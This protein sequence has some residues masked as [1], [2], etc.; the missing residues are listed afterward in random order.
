MI[1]QANYRPIFLMRRSNLGLSLWMALCGITFYFN[2][3]VTQAQTY[4]LVWEDEFNQFDPTTPS[5]NS[6]YNRWDVDRTAWNIEVVDA[7]ANGEIQKYRDS[8]DN[9]RLEVNPANSQDGILVIESKRVNTTQNLGAW[10]SGRM[11]SKGK[12]KFQY[13]LIE[14]RAKLPPLLGSWPAI[15]MMGD[16]I[17]TLGWPRCG[18][19][20]IMEMGRVTGWNSILGTIHWNAPGSPAPPDYSYAYVGSAGSNSNLAVPDSTTAFHVYRIEWTP[21][22]IR[23]FV[24]GTNYYTQNISS[25]TGSPTNP[26][27]SYDFHLLLNNA[28]GGSMGGTVNTTGPASTRYEVDYV[29]VY[30]QATSDTILTSK[31][32]LPTS[33]VTFPSGVSATKTIELANYPHSIT[34]TGSIPG[35]TA[36]VTST[37]TPYSGFTGSTGKARLVLSGTP[38][39]TGTFTLQ[40]QASN[41]AGTSS[42]SF[43]VVVTGTSWSLQNGNFEQ[44]S[45]NLPTSWSGSSS[46]IA[47]IFNDS[48]TASPDPLSAGWTRTGSVSAPAY[49]V[50]TPSSVYY[51]SATLFTPYSGSASLKVY[52]PYMANNGA[53][54][55]RFYRTASA[56]AGNTYQFQAYAHTGNDDSIRGGNVCRLY[57]EFLNSANVVLGTQYSTAEMKAS[58]PRGNWSPLQ[59]ALAVAPT[60][61]VTIRAGTEFIQPAGWNTSDSNGCVYWDDFKLDSYFTTTSL[62]FNTSG[63]ALRLFSS[64]WAEQTVQAEPNATYLFSGVNAA[65]SGSVKATV[66]YQNDAGT[67]VASAIESTF[68]SGQTWQLS[69]TSPASAAR[70]LLRLSNASGTVDINETTWAL[71]GRSQLYNGG[72]ETTDN[73]LPIA[74]QTTGTSSTYAALTSSGTKSGAYAL[75]VGAPSIGSNT[76]SGWTQD[77]L[78]STPGTTWL[79]EVWSRNSTPLAGGNQGLLRLEFLNLSGSVM[80]TGESIL[81]KSSSFS[82]SQIYLRAPVGSTQARLSLLLNQVDYSAGELVFDTAEVRPLA[83]SDYLASRANT[84]GISTPDLSPTSDP[85]N[86]G[87]PSAAEFLWGTDPFSASSV[88]RLGLGYTSTP[89]TFKL[90]WLAVPGSTY[91]INQSPNLET[92]STPTQTFEVTPS[93]TAGSTS[94]FTA[95]YEVPMT[96]LK[97]FY[98]IRPK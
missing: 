23:W 58:S 79:A 83:E 49:E 30:Q 7:P 71:V 72:V 55:T 59:T 19:I 66:T 54:T 31:P 37:S 80:L 34:V 97:S 98:R 69:S 95:E 44:G 15:W 52:G 14:V 24:D 76:F 32:A 82:R 21:T 39:Q 8:R 17:D 45:G 93:S 18:E 11:N 16:N 29:R 38:S 4:R 88:T 75:R 48:I 90:S 27:T 50:A 6:L 85:D 91:I 20:D 43:P 26:F 36:T 57:L 3:F 89:N 64:G 5:S 42:L 63:Q 33:Q 67:A 1:L 74:W 2:P 22:Q 35:M 41:V 92:I 51:N 96:S 40:L 47:N 61:T 87:V 10:T 78:V 81:P 56:I 84:S 70:A 12:I 73:N 86:D 60:G 62:A 68:S 53:G 13:G 46:T 25:I 65:G 28:M 77:M 9:V 94:P